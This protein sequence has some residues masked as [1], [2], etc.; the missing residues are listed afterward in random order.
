MVTFSWG[1]LLSFSPDLWK[2][3][4]RLWVLVT[5]FRVV[6]TASRPF[7]QLIGLSATLPNIKQ[8]AQWL[9]NAALYA[10]DFRQ[11]V[12]SFPLCRTASVLCTQ[13]IKLCAFMPSYVC[14]HCVLG[15]CHFKKCTKSA[16]TSTAKTV[17]CFAVCTTIPSSST[18]S[19]RRRSNALNVSQKK[20]ARTRLLLL[21]CLFPWSPRP[22]VSPWP[23]YWR[24]IRT[25]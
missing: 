8:I 11:V 25:I 22:A 2:L 10:T 9:G 19:G 7:I 12:H 18:T 1:F 15:Q 17:F 13:S 14:G 24:T 4:I 6:Y 3:R 21:P 23:P 20:E 16:R 5:G